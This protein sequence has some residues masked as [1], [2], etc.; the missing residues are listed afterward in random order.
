M[1]TLLGNQVMPAEFGIVS[2]SKIKVF[3]EPKGAENLDVT[4]EC[5]TSME[6]NFIL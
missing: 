6:K 3:A 4:I 5:Y 1:V 2:I